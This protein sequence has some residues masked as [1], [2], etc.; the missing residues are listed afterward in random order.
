MTYRFQAFRTLTLAVALGLQAGFGG[1]KRTCHRWGRGKSAKGER[2]D[3]GHGLSPTH[4]TSSFQGTA[5]TF[6]YFEGVATVQE[7]AG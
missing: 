2:R 5:A 4:G 7:R 1:T 3:Q 6:L